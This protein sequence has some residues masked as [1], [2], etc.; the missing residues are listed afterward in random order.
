MTDITQRLADA[1]RAA[2]VAYDLY[3]A[4][5]GQGAGY[6]RATYLIPTKGHKLEVLPLWFI[7][8]Q[9]DKFNKFAADSPLLHFHVTRIGCGL[10]GLKDEEIAPM[11]KPALPNCSYPQEWEKYLTC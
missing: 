5:Y 6:C 10:A 7:K 8:E 9:V 11:F 1:L 4:E 3:G 2:E